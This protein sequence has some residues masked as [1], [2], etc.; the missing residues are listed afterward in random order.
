MKRITRIIVSLLIY[1]L[2]SFTACVDPTTVPPS[3]PQT[4]PTSPASTQQQVYKL[5]ISVIPPEAGDVISYPSYGYERGTE[6]KLTADSAVGYTFN[7]W[8]GDISGSANPF[9][10][11]MNSDKN[12][13]A[14][15]SERPIFGIVYPIRMTAKY[16]YVSHIG[17][18]LFNDSS[19][20]ITIK[21]V[22]VIDYTS[23]IALKISDERTYQSDWVS[24]ADTWGN[25]QINPGK[26]LSASYRLFE[27]LGKGRVSDHVGVEWDYLDSAGNLFTIYDWFF[28]SA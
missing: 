20:A 12:I 16:G 23:H 11:T 27:T 5:T 21:E 6:V 17:F 9:T 14:Y 1:S 28:V 4:S 25:R 18:T 22:R 15:F 26:S 19:Q 2:F 7:N 8:G 13:I 24:I 10:I 3:V